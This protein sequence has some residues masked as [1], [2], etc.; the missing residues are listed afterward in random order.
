MLGCSRLEACHSEER[1]VEYKTQSEEPQ[2]KYKHDI[3]SHRFLLTRPR[4]QD[5]QEDACVENTPPLFWAMSIS[6]AAIVSFMAAS[7]T[8]RKLCGGF[9]P[10]NSVTAYKYLGGLTFFL[11]FWNYVA[12]ICFI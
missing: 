6:W 3:M 4:S 5:M 11:R 10:G 1:H 7:Q 9:G 2:H 8:V 12:F